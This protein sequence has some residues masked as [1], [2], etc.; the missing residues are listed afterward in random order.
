MKILI[1]IFILITS[2]LVALGQSGDVKKLGSDAEVPRITVEE[3]KKGFD[4]GSVVFVD[5]RAADIYAAEHIKGAVSIKGAGEDR[6]DSLPK[7]KK[8]IVYCS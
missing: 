1:S 8:I 5:A 6:F 3:A 4:N 7:G 2:A